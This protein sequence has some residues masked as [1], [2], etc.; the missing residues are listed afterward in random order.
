MSKWVWC[1]QNEVGA[2]TRILRGHHP[3]EIM[4]PNSTIFY[5]WDYREAVSSIRHQLWLRCRGECELCGSLVTEQGGHMH[6]QQHRGKGGEISLDNSV[7][8]CAKCH[9][10]AHK[11]RAP[12]F[13][14]KS[15]TSE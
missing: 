11:D 4:R 1:E 8:I 3:P 6:E 5:D 7:F 15:L 13:T 10:D 14:K 9:Q 12:R 2:V